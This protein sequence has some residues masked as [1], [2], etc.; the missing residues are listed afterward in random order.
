MEKIGIYVTEE[1]AQFLRAQAGSMS[2]WV[3]SAIEVH[4]QQHDRLQ[5]LIDKLEASLSSHATPRPSSEPPASGPLVGL[6]RGIGE[7]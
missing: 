3:R 4:R 1:Q 5:T 2:G 6:R 7:D